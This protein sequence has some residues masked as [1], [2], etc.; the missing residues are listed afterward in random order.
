VGDVGAGEESIAAAD[1]GRVRRARPAV[2]RYH[3][4]EGVIVPDRDA[5]RLLPVTE[6]LRPF[7]DHCPDADMVPRPHDEGA[8]Q[9][10]TGP[11]VTSRSQPNVAFQDGARLDDDVIGQHNLGPNDCGRMDTTVL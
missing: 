6:V 1:A 7:T 9:L 5:R 3:F 8:D 4:T 10:R 11:D 2:D